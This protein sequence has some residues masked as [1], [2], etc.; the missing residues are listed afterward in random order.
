MQGLKVFFAG[1]WRLRRIRGRMGECGEAFF[2]IRRSFMR[3][4]V[5]IL[6]LLACGVLASVSYAFLRIRDRQRT[7][8]S[9]D[10]GARLAAANPKLNSEVLPL[11][12]QYCWDCHGDG[13]DKGGVNLDGFTNATQVFA[14]R[15]LWERV[16]DNVKN[17]SMPPP[18][19]K[20]PAPPDREKL[21]AWLDGVL[22]PIDSANP[23]PGRVTLR[24]LNRSEYN[25]TVRD[26]LG[27][28]FKPADDFPQD[29]VGYGF[30]NIGD[31]L[32]LPPVLLEKYLRAAQDVVEAALP[33]GA[34]KPQTRHFAPNE[35]QGHDR[36]GELYALLAKEGEVFVR[37]PVRQAADYLLQV[38]AF[39]KQIPERLTKERVK[40]T[41]RL[42]DR[43]LLT[44]DV[45]AKSEN[46]RNYEYRLPLAV[47]EQTF[48]VGFI[49]ESVREEIKQETRPKGET[50]TVTNHFDR[51]LCIN[52]IRII[53]PFTDAPPPPTEF[54][55]WLFGFGPGVTN[56]TQLPENAPAVLERFAARAFRRPVLPGELSRLSEL[57]RVARI[58]QPYVA[59]LRH[60]LTAVLLSPHFLF[61]GEIQAEP[62]NPRAIHPINE[63]A[64]AARLSYFLWS[65]VTDETLTR[66]AARGELR[67]EIKGQ[68]QRLLRDPKSRALTENFAGQWLQLR[69][70]DLV[71]PDKVQFPDFDESLRSSMRR[72]TTLLF[73]HI[74]RDNRPITEFLT[75]DYTFVNERLARHY[76]IKGVQ[77]DEFQR[78][79]LAGTP[80]GGVLT[81]ASFLTFSSNPTRTSPVK[82]GKWVLDN[83]LGLPPPPPPP[84]VPELGERNLKGTLRQRLE[85]HRNNPM[86]AT[87]HSRMDPIGF[88]LE[89]FD[90]VGRFRDKDGT[91]AID[92]ADKLHTGE[93]FADHSDLRR[94]LA[95]SHAADFGR[96]LSEKLLTYALGR[97]IEWY[98][99]P[100]LLQI[101][102]RLAKQQFQFGEL[103]QAI[104]ESV[105]FQRRR[106][107]GDPLNPGSSSPVGNQARVD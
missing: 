52:S 97:G 92:S 55:K 62:D 96:T 68:V 74:L 9:I 6:F 47:G 4:S 79:D 83:L 88:A 91:T 39:G 28:E 29:D 104:V 50:V 22:Y 72:E 77:G 101:Q 2:V 58:E 51:D 25:N 75:A 59:A 26:L 99:R 37:F 64:L 57:Y 43:I 87:C 90:A 5:L 19:K 66:L 48:S 30:D 98:D 7:H 103:I 15:V 93:A 42:G 107:E 95:T 40:M 80:R 105:P 12:Q 70:L 56:L 106:G 82:R 45:A 36:S 18:K 49:N 38:T 41:F 23:D 13:A 100:A 32:S 35:I 14:Q 73:D 27:V 65:S 24:R 3:R 11:L 71:S 63:Y 85:E 61:R 81:H 33:L 60:A 31:V 69:L 76:G 20:Q 78:V 67:R 54:Q 102:E 34:A 44:N 94:I 17:G 1:V 86:C 21:I 16:M 53:G 84:N 10:L 46:P 89:H 8:S